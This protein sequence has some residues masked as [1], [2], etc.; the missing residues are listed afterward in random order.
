MDNLYSAYYQSEIGILKIT[1]SEDALVSLDFVNATT[2]PEPAKSNRIIEKTIDQ[3]NQYF[4]GMRHDFDLDLDPRGTPFQKRVW[5]KLSEIPYGK[6]VS[7]SDIALRLGDKGAVRAVGLANKK[8][9]I[10]I[11]I[12][13]HRVIGTDGRLIGYAGGIHR[14]EWLLR[15]EKAIL[16]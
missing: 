7:Y 4:S 16:I 15:H 9:P 13:C 1:A 12:P 10:A 5:E 3:L 8:N 6:T 2:K 14:K 11:I